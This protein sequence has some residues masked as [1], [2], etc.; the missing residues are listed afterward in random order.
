MGTITGSKKGFFSVLPLIE[1]Q[2][3]LLDVFRIPDHEQDIPGGEFHV[4]G[5]IG[6]DLRIA[7]D[8]QQREGVPQE[9]SDDLRD[10]Q[11]SKG[12]NGG[13]SGIRTRGTPLKGVQ[14][15]SRR[16]LSATQPSLRDLFFDRLSRGHLAA[17]C[18]L[19]SGRY[20]WRREQDSNPRT[21]RSTVF[22]TAAIDH[23]AI[24]PYV[25]R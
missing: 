20:C 7:V 19:W 4:G 16:S 6:H 21:F 10:E 11:G 18:P 3:Y 9:E 5:R 25:L 13:E 15:L 22:K 24:P 17:R 12:E 23:S 2:P 8:G 1:D 14:S